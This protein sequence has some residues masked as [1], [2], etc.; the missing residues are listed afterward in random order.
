[1]PLKK[2]NNNEHKLKV[3]YITNYDTMYGANRSLFSLMIALKSYYDIEPYLLVPGGG[4]IGRYCELNGISVIKADFRISYVKSDIKHFGFRRIT[5]RIMR[6]YD[7]IRILYLLHRNALSFDIIHSNSSIFDIGYY[8]AK[9]CGIPHFW[10]VREFAEKSYN[11]YSCLSDLKSVEEYNRSYMIAVSNAIYNMLVD[12]GC[13]EERIRRIYNGVDIP[14]EYE[15]EYYDSDVVNFCMVGVVNTEKNQIDVVEACIALWRKDYR[16][17]KLHIIGGCTPEYMEQINQI[18]DINEGI[19]GS[20]VFYGHRDDVNELLKKMDVGI[21]AST[22]E[23]F[24]RVTVEYMA[25][26][27]PVIATD[28]GAT[29]E[30]L[31]DLG[32]YYHVHDYDE[33]ANIMEKYLKKDNVCET[34]GKF[35]RERSLNFNNETNA[36]NIYG[37]YM[38]VLE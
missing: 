14:S 28:S 35:M 37:Y 25:N 31:G 34:N 32:D 10:H 30:I 4:N 22:C 33:L 36:E 15:K 20:V 38:D 17:F 16:N 24:G 27:M 3:L 12:K 1:M 18:I 5:R 6:H 8:L 21:M 2:K 9:R 13:N 29:K 23:A 26:Y 19:Q 11:L 7:V